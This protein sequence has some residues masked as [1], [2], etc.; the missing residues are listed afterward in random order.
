MI[1]EPRRGTYVAHAET[2]RKCYEL[3]VAAKI[4]VG[5]TAHAPAD[6][7]DTL[8]EQAQENYD[9][10][11]EMIERLEHAE[12]GVYVEG[13][14]SVRGAA[15]EFSSALVDFRSDVLDAIHD[16]PETPVSTE[17]MEAIEAKKTATYRA[18]LNFL[19]RASDAIGGDG[20]TGRM[21]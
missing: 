19:Y 1:R 21:N 4:K 14:A 9:A 13:P 16:L 8:I 18:Y 6:A 17:R 12:A 3:V 11:I 10:A 2:S 7:I 5:L 20:I 15:I